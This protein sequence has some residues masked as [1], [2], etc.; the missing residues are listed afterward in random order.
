[1]LT[2]TWTPSRGVEIT[3]ADLPDPWL[4]AIDRLSDDLRVRHYGG[5]IE[6]IDWVAE[7]DLDG[8]AVWLGSAVTITGKRANGLNG[9]GTGAHI[10]ADEDAA[11]W[12][13]ADLVQNAIAE[14]GT[15]WPW[16]DVGGFMKP[17]LVDELAVWKDK[18]GSTTRIGD[19]T[20]ST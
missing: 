7:Y 17:Q 1:M 20:E 8:G 10:D 12:S 18:N 14:A 2:A 3:H 5:D 13:M 6:H 4:L 11:L 16:G 9:N 15:A 19:L